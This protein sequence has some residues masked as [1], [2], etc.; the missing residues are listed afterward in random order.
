MNRECDIIYFV[1]SGSGIVHTETGNFNLAPHDA[2]LIT[3]GNWYWVEGDNFKIL[4]VS[5][6]EW[7]AEQY[8]EV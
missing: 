5:S 1:L 4:I 2:L 6:P 3:R 7:N 8:K